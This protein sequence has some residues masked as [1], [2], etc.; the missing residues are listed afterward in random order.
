MRLRLCF[1][2]P[3]ETSAVC[4]EFKSTVETKGTRMAL[5]S[6]VLLAALHLFHIAEFKFLSDFGHDVIR[7][8]E[9]GK[10]KKEEQCKNKPCV[11][12][13]LQSDESGEET[14]ALTRAR[15]FAACWHCVTLALMVFHVEG[16]NAALSS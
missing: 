5:T 8:R 12:K 1:H 6:F 16:C 9:R 4:K 7:G 13:N 3:T 2:L 14:R 10:K 15:L 11:Y